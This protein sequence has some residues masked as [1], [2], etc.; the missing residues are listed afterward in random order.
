[1]SR[2]FDSKKPDFT[3]YDGVTPKADDFLTM[4][5]YLENLIIGFSN[6]LSPGIIRASSLLRNSA[7]TWTL[8]TG[9]LLA[10]TR[11]IVLLDSLVPPLPT[12]TDAEI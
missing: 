7:T 4:M 12:I 3:Q 9:S 5:T 8:T 10:T 6:V 11:E 2:S 1:M